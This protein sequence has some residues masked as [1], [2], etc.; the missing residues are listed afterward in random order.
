MNFLTVDE[1]AEKL[2]L[3]P[4]SIRKHIREGTIFASKLG[5]GKRSH[6]RIPDSELE[7][8]FLQG[9]CEKNK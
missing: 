9:M 1:F 7:R 3:H 4:S 8:L 2:K 6:Y 5:S